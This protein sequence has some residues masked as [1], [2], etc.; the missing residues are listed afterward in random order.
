[1]RSH[2]YRLLKWPEVKQA[3]GDRAVVVVPVAAIKITNLI[4]FAKSFR[5][6]LDLP[7]LDLNHS[8]L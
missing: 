7:D 5:E 6:M 2:L 4:E 3:A 8:Q 1:M